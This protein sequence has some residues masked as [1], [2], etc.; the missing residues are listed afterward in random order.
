MSKEI[1]FLILTVPQLAHTKNI[2]YLPSFLS[3]QLP[4][5]HLTSGNASSLCELHTGIPCAFLTKD[6]SLQ[7]GHGVI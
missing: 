6:G 3:S 7:N 2:P 4:Q 1:A 5:E